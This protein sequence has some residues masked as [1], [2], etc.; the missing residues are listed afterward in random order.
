M[1]GQ[2][3]KNINLVYGS[4][5]LEFHGVGGEWEGASGH[6]R[7]EQEDERSHLQ[8][9]ADSRDQTG[10]DAKLQTF[11]P[12]VIPPPSRLY[13]EDGPQS[14]QTALTGNRV[15]KHIHIWGTFFIQPTIRSYVAQVA[16]ELLI[17]LPPAPMDWEYFHE[18]ACTL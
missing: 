8:P 6:R 14:L 17:F 9:H 2:P 10:S 12:R 16:L 3:W 7:L 11:Q 4:G 18:P 5:G 13:L 15:F 1:P